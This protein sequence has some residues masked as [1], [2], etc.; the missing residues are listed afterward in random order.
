MSF[1]ILS[2][3]ILC[4][5]LLVLFFMV[6]PMGQPTISYTFEGMSYGVTRN[7]ICCPSYLLGLISH[8]YGLY[9]MSYAS[10]YSF[11]GI[12]FDLNGIPYGLYVV[13][14][15]LYAMSYGVYG[16][17]NGFTVHQNWHALL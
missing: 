8:E 10:L 9:A 13:F 1:P 12:S 6:S 4:F 5:C 14:Y 15:T 11:S 17:S 16:I 7:S 3:F 2:L